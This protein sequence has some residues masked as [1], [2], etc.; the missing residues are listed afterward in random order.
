M[1]S[2]SNI[3]DVESIKKTVIEGNK[4]GAVELARE[5][6]K[7]KIEP[8][9]VIDAYVEGI[10]I[11]GDGFGRG[12]IFLPELIISAEAMKA[13]IDI[14][15][16]EVLKRGETREKSGKI[17]IGTVEGDIHDIGKTIVGSILSANGFEVID[18]GSN[19]KPSTFI[20]KIKDTNADILGMSAL[21]TTTMVNQKK[22]IEEL[23]KE[24]LRSRVKVIIGGAPTSAEWA[25]DIGADGW[26]KDAIDALKLAKRLMSLD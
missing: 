13:A 12:E 3:L 7:K 23:E 15:D 22:T 4:E 20:E 5:A 24:G 10:R 21:L 6:L 18:I 11:V 25:E 16:E 26:G 2:D 1:G 9:K 8:L 19:V 17:V 14:L